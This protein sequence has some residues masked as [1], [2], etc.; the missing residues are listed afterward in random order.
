M[1]YEILMT[2]YGQNQK[3]CAQMLVA[4]E[5]R[6]ETEARR[7]AI[8]SA[9]AGMLFVTSFDRITVKESAK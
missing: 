8:H 2:V 4:P 3:R 5:A 6:D 7:M 1:R 9:R